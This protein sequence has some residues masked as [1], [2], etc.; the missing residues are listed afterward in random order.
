M[1]IGE[2]HV[3]RKAAR[4]PGLVRAGLRYVWNT[5]A[6]RVPLVVMLLVYLFTFNFSVVVP[7]HAYRTFDGSAQ[8]IGWLYA[9]LGLGAFLGAIA[10]AN[11]Q[12]EPT[13]RRLAGFSVAFGV[14]LAG[15]GL[16]P[17]F[18]LAL[19]AMVPVGYASMLFAITANST[20]QQFTRAD[21]R[22]RVMALYTTIFLG[23]TAVGGPITGW[24]A[25][26][27]GAPATFVAG[28]AVAVAAG[29]VALRA[30]APAPARVEP[31]TADTA[32][33]SA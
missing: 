9:A 2:L 15:A 21:M 4:E 7:L 10:M 32:A 14:L 22:G 1:R 8:E 26:T 20:L 6:L 3:Q 31:V 24:V 29:L 25:E 12:T 11:R 23:S 13:L 33:R 17:A 28:G 18:V 30:R 5:Q 19:A 27:W 16:A